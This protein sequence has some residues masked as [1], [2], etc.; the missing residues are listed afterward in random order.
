MM[1]PQP[2]YAPQQPAFVPQQPVFAP[3]QLM[4]VWPQ[5]MPQMVQM[6][7]PPAQVQT[8]TQDAPR[9]V[10]QPVPQ[11]FNI[12]QTPATPAGDARL[13]DIQRSIEEFRSALTDFARRKSA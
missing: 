6:P 12:H 4:Q 7:M 11:I 5:A 9:P 10:A 1:Y 8:F 13:D 2:V 3:Q